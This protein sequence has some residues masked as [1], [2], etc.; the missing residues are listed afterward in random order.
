MGRPRKDEPRDQQLNVRFTAA[1]FARIYRHAS[2]AGKSVP[3]FS[4]AVL[5]RRPR[6]SRSKAA[7]ELIALSPSALAAWQ[8]AGARLNGIAHAMNAREILPPTALPTL[9]RELE[10]LLGLHFR[11]LPADRHYALAPPVRFHLRKVGANLVQIRQ[12]HD[13]LGLAPPRT[14]ITSLGTIRRIMAHD[15]APDAA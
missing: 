7:P 15:R 2:L 1:E 10:A 4:R 6:K 14:L 13:A 11:A 12:R 5:L 3:E 8:E 9:L